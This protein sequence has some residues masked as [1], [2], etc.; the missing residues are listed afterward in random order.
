MGGD[1]ARVSH[2]GRGRMVQHDPGF[3]DVAQPPLDVPFEAAR[4][5]MPHR[6]GRGRRERGP[7][8][9]LAQDRR[10]RVGDVVALERALAG[11]HFVE[12]GAERPHVATLVSRASLGLLGTHVGGGAKDQADL[13]H[14]GAGDR[15]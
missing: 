6:R 11:Q 15:R 8:D 10:Q 14:R 7:V 13:G 5:Q 2:G 3:A 1:S 9:V 4:E 12:H